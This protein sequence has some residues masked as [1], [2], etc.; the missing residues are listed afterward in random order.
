MYVAIMVILTI[1]CLVYVFVCFHLLICHMQ[2]VYAFELHDKCW[3][4]SD[5]Y[6]HRAFQQTCYTLKSIVLARAL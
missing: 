5:I 6:S 3:L 2:L 1:T 4:R